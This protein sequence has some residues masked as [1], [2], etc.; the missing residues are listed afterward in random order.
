MIDDTS[1]QR[2]VAQYRREGYGYVAYPDTEQH[3]QGCV[4]TQDYGISLCHP[5]R[6]LQTL[7]VIPLIRLAGYMERGWADNHDVAM[8]AKEDRDRPWTPEFRNWKATER[9]PD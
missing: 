9:G 6:L 3:D 8:I 2:I 1:W 5:D 7:R 4:K